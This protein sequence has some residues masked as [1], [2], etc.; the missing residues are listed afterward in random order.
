MDT[1]KIKQNAKEQVEQLNE[2]LEKLQKQRDKLT[3]DAQATFEE[4]LEH[5]KE[6]REKLVQTYDEFKSASEIN[7][8]IVQKSFDNTADSIKSGI[9]ELSELLD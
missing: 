1:D 3:E 4:K 5:L 6:Q 9:N 2:K 8:N 7:W